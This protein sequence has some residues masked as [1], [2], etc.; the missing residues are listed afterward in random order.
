M[1]NK[2]QHML[3]DMHARAHAGVSDYAGPRRIGWIVAEGGG[4][5][6]S[7]NQMKVKSELSA[8]ARM[9]TAS[10]HVHLRAGGRDRCAG[11]RLS[12]L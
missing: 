9:Y 6:P 4:Q 5:T 11:S 8:M 7:N 1:F 2:C 12:F 3:A 10:A